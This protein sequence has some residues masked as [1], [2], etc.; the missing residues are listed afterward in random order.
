MIKFYLVI[1][2]IISLI[3]SIVIQQVELNN[4]KVKDILFKKSKMI[5]FINKKDD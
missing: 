4:Y 2:T 5:E 3:L 1:G